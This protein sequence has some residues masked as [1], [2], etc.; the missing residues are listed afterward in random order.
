MKKL[1]WVRRSLGKLGW[2]EK[3]L[4]AQRTAEKERSFHLAL[5]ELRKVR[6]GWD[7]ATSVFSSS[8]VRFCG[9]EFENCDG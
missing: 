5:K 7:G 8:A 9:I 1:A 3:G 2:L 6:L 4:N